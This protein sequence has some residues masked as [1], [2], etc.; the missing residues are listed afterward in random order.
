MMQRM[1][2]AGVPRGFLFEKRLIA[3]YGVPDRVPAQNNTANQPEQKNAW[4]KIADALTQSDAVDT[5]AQIFR[6]LQQQFQ[7][8]AVDM[9][10]LKE[11]DGYVR[12]IATNKLG[13][14]LEQLRAVEPRSLQQTYQFILEV[15]AKIGAPQTSPDP[16]GQPLPPVA[17]QPRP[18]VPAPV[19]VTQSPSPVNPAP[20]PVQTSVP[21][22]PKPIPSPV[23]ATPKSGP[24]PAT[25][26]VAPTPSALINILSKN[27]SDNPQEFW[28][29]YE[30]LMKATADS[31]MI[32]SKKMSDLRET[33]KSDPQLYTMTMQ[34]VNEALDLH[35][36]AEA[37]VTKEENYKPSD[38]VLAALKKDYPDAY[39]KIENRRLIPDKSIAYARGNLK[40]PRNTLENF[41]KTLV[42][43]Q[44]NN[45]SI[46]VIL[47]DNNASTVNE[48][49]TKNMPIN[50]RIESGCDL[51]KWDTNLLQKLETKIGHVV[52][53][54]DIPVGT[55]QLPLL[56][57]AQ[58]MTIDLGKH[59]E[60][61]KSFEKPEW[62]ELTILS[63]TY[64][65]DLPHAVLSKLIHTEWNGVL[66]AEYVQDFRWA[67]WR[68]GIIDSV[69]LYGEKLNQQLKEHL[70]SMVSFTFRYAENRGAQPQNIQATKR[71]AAQVSLDT[72]LSEFVESFVT[73]YQGDGYANRNAVIRN[74][75]IY[76]YADGNPKPVWLPHNGGDLR[77]P[78]QLSF[79]M[80][81]VKKFPEGLRYLRYG[82]L[83]IAPS[84]L[85]EIP[86]SFQ[87]VSK[88][89][90]QGCTALASLPV[91][92]E[93]ATDVKLQDLKDG[94]VTADALRQWKNKV[95]GRI[96]IEQ[97]ML[98]EIP[99]DLKD[100]VFYW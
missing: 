61:F 40:E 59:V 47:R 29:E 67:F 98:K 1:F 34:E 55:L 81:G 74:G 94:V 21:V 30:P 86:K 4:A 92:I 33:T 28:K 84:S 96:L 75:T 85:K 46:V 42:D 9:N 60:L 93:V 11:S 87:R 31:G 68:L 71:G 52:L 17:L 24:I 97:S 58:S 37:A 25:P 76:A 32:F 26:S 13:F 100:K 15:L 20:T 45:P 65:K 19:S 50:L 14:T 49:L 27:P 35:K 62:K 36:K 12:S 3:R 70:P 23:P 10:Y 88:L 72:E 48:A 7:Q 16:T 78:A 8:R 54:G 53:T 83:V 57:K 18:V 69:D 43:R 44:R 63:G 41:R 64:D 51:S 6:T 56:R 80:E 2:I 99:D 39:K 90:I 91:H 79:R 38:K 77:D 95:G 73:I 82:T 66:H 22:A 89:L 5:T